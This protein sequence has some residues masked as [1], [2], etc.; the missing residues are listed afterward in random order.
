MA[1][2]HPDHQEYRRFTGKQRSEKA[3]A[4]LNGILKGITIDDTLN[5]TEIAELLNWCNDHS[6]LKDLAPFNE[7]IPMFDR[8]MAD[9]IIDVDEQEDLLWLCKNLSRDSEFFDSITTD[10]QILQGIL[11]G[12][13]SDRVISLEEATNLQKWMEKNEHLKGTYPYDELDSIL[14][15]ILADK[16][17]DEEEHKRLLEFFDD[18]SNLSM[19]SKIRN[20]RNGETVSYSVNGVCATCPEIAVPEQDSYGP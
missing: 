7:L 12:I 18:F 11:H 5:P 1:L 19:T 10:L 17:I 6:D 2:H 14:I 4:T 3:I 15:D 8:I 16:E 13:S 20:A 9:G